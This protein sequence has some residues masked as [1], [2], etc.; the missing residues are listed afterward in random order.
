MAGNG[1]SA[2]SA[3]AVVVADLRQISGIGGWLG[4]ELFLGF[5]LAACATCLLRRLKRQ[6]RLAAADWRRQQP[7]GVADWRQISSG[8]GGWLGQELFLGFALVACAMRL[9][10]GWQISCGGSWSGQEVCSGFALAA[11]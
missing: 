4:Q 9:Q 1:R 6:W 2:V 8:G 11:C 10:L 7:A 3:T 5:S